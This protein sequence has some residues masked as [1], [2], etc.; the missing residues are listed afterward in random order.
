V[1]HRFGKKKKKKKKNGRAPG[2]RYSLRRESWA[3]SLVGRGKT[4]G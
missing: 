3:V 2:K 1:N 4:F